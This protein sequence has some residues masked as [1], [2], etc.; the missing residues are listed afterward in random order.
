MD[1]GEF[2]ADVG[3]LLVHF[4]EPSLKTLCLIRVEKLKLDTSWLPR[5][6]QA[7][8]EVMTMPNKITP[9]PLNHTG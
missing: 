3:L 5:E 2:S 9:K 8:L 4:A 1:F 7:L 6:L